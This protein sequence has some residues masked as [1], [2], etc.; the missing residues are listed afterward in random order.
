MTIDVEKYIIP[1]D[2]IDLAK[3]L[4]TWVWLT[5]SKSIVG[6]T[7]SGDALLKN[8]QDHL[9]FLDVG[10]GT[11]EFKADNYQDFF[12]QKLNY[13]LTEELLLPVL[14]DKLELHGI[15]LKPKQVYSYIIL[16]I[17]GG[18]YDEKN[19]YAVDLYEHYNLTGEMHFQLKDLPDGTKVDTEVKD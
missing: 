6:L 9:F 5:S 4:S 16:P 12:D 13:E 3:I 2:K 1:L 11:C 18:A 8:E 19:I 17:I 15:I 7:K 10:G 14:V